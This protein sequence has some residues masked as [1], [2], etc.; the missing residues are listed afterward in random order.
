MFEQESINFV[1][2]D[3]LSNFQKI[4]GGNILSPFDIYFKRKSEDNPKKIHKVNS[5]LESMA[6]QRILRSPEKFLIEE[7]N[8]EDMQGDYLSLL[9]QLFVLETY[10]KKRE[11]I[12]NCLKKLVLPNI[13]L[14][15]SILI[16]E[17]NFPIDDCGYKYL[18]DIEILNLEI[19]LLFEIIMM[20]SLGLVTR[21]YLHEHTSYFRQGKRINGD[22]FNKVVN[23]DYTGLR[24]K[25][26]LY[27]LI[28]DHFLNYEIFSQLKKIIDKSLHTPIIIEK[29]SQAA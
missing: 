25:T 11:I 17:M 22:F 26:S 20:I 4:F 2:I 12:V 19:T 18:K 10:E 8:C 27:N 6:R 21:E 5:F 3:K 13:P 15:S 23:L 16:M 7:K 24:K 9:D 1:S 14:N 28:E 29:E